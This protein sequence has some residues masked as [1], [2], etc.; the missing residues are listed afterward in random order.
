[1]SADSSDAKE[2]IAFARE[3]LQVAEL[4]LQAG[5]LNASLHNAQQATE[6]ALKAIRLVRG[7]GLKRTHSIRELNDDLRRAGII[8]DLT[9]E[10]TELLD[11]IYVGSK[12][13]GESVLPTAPPDRVVC[14]RC[15]DLV[16]QVLA[17]AENIAGAS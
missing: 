16:K 8:V 15:V 6:K 13:P 1:M 5:L 14:R 3:N 12:Y 17:T 4:T 11:S 7:L 10:D 2:W 9:Q